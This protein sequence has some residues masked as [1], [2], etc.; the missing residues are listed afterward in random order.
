VDKVGVL[1][2][3][4]RAMMEAFS[5]R[6]AEA[7]A[8]HTLFGLLLPAFQSFLD[9]NVRKEIEKDRRVIA[10]AAAALHA[11]RA[12]D[13]TDA[14]RLLTEARDIDR[15]F[16]RQATPFP[17]TLRIHYDDIEPA[18]R[19]RIERLLDLGHRLLASWQGT[20]KFR[21]AA[22]AIFTRAQFLAAQREIL[23]LYALETRMLG[24]SVSVPRLFAPAR[25]QLADTIYS[26]METAAEG[27][28]GECTGRIY[29]PGA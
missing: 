20:R 28:A 4:D 13:A 23:R 8:R 7:L 26:V 12:P 29:G 18:R 2:A 6:T 10:A 1:C 5:R 19:R 15:T 14:A 24:N 9:I 21:A 11:G 16:L 17:L 22:A 27:L 25:A 3:M